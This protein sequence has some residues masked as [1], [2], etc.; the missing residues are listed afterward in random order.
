M[1]LTFLYEA[2]DLCFSFDHNGS[3]RILESP[4]LDQ[5]KEKKDYHRI[6][7]ST[8]KRFYVVPELYNCLQAS[9][10]R[11]IFTGVLFVK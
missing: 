10:E 5:F 8:G 9:D 3:R 4:L 7:A 11:F 1:V 2:A 6:V